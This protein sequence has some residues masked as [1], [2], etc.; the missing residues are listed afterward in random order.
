MFWNLYPK[1]ALTTPVSTFFPGHLQ[2]KEAVK[3]QFGVPAYKSHKDLVK[4]T[5]DVELQK[6]VEDD[7]RRYGANDV[8]E[9]DDADEIDDEDD[10]A[11]SGKRSRR[12]TRERGTIDQDAY[13]SEEEDYAPRRRRRIPKRGATTKKQKKAPNAPKGA[14]SAFMFFSQRMQP[15]IRKEDPSL[16]FGEVGKKVGALWKDLSAD[17]RVEYEELAKEDKLRHQEEMAEYIKANPEAAAEKKKKKTKAPAS[18]R[19]NVIAVGSTDGAN[20][21]RELNVFE[22]A[23]LAIKVDRKRKDIDEADTKA[24]ANVFVQKMND[25]HTDDEKLTRKHLPA[26]KKMAM[27]PEVVSQTRNRE[28]V[29]EILIEAGLLAAFGDWLHTLADGS[30]PNKKLRETIYMLLEELTIISEHHLS[31]AD[32]LGKVLMKLAQHPQETPLNK[33]RLRT[34]IHKWLYEIF[35]MN[36]NYQNLMEIE[37]EHQRE[38]MNRKKRIGDKPI[39][40]PPKDAIRAQIPSRA[41]FD[42]ARRPADRIL[43]NDRED[44]QVRDRRA[45]KTFKGEKQ[46]SLMKKFADGKRTSASRA[47]DV[48]VVGKK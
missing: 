23:Q 12:K 7:S 2:I 22:K 25:A 39:H 15:E 44:F 33:K 36:S 10:D 8:D 38:I 32:Q 1:Y 24:A 35:G 21:D 4:T 18:K 46:M 30:L 11:V 6:K 42:Y 41:A 13:D 5:I 37:D 28:D 31:R 20:P 3:S 26:T 9:E 19:R 48:D 29:Q 27:L 16:P 43:L 47:A 45:R 14:R 17:D 40:R 34:L